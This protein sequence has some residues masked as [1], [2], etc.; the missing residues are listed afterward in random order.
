MTAPPLDLRALKAQYPLADY[1][2]RKAGHTLVKASYGT[3]KTRCPFHEERSASLVLYPD[4]HYHCYGCG[5]HGDLFD[6]LEKLHGLDLKAALTHLTG[7]DP[8]DLLTVR[9]APAPSTRPAEPDLHTLTPAE[10]TRWRTS[11][12]TFLTDEAEIERWAEWRG[13]H[14]G[15]LRAAAQAGLLGTHP[16]HR[17]PREAFLILRPAHP[18]GLLPHS[19]HV[20]LSPHTPGN[21]TDRQSW[22]YD[23]TSGKK[24]RV[25]SYPFLYAASAMP[26]QHEMLICSTWNT[27]HLRYLLFTE[28]QWDALAL[29]QALGWHSPAAVPAHTAIIGL[30]GASS[31][32]RYLDSCRPRPDAIALCFADA[33][34]A[35]D[36]WFTAAGFVPQLQEVCREVVAYRPTHPGCKDLNDLL[37]AG[38]LDDL[39][40]QLRARLTP[41]ARPAEPGRRRPFISHLRHLL[42]TTPDTQSEIQAALRHVLADPHKPASARPPHIWTTYLA[43]TPSPDLLL[44]LWRSWLELDGS[45][46]RPPLAARQSPPPG[47]PHH[48]PAR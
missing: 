48:A 19:V 45:I 41:V 15:L 36:L 26:F 8:H 40:E 24:Y 35:G 11:C 46:A 7:R 32:R 44:S 5:A 33:D 20:R 37:K 42:K 28:G 18:A 2:T 21:D 39:R 23:P 22:R 4:H 47:L 9:T 25:V 29:A 31:W 27:Q 34:R 38:H 13:L 43:H 6:Y 16:Y 3:F 30:R 12:E 1:L 14:P 17:Q 10:I